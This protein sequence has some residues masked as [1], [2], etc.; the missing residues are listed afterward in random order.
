MWITKLL[1]NSTRGYGR[2]LGVL[3]I[4][5]SMSGKF[6]VHAWSQCGGLNEELD[7]VSVR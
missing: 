6:I 3:H 2:E 7:Q 1:L 5:L 4:I